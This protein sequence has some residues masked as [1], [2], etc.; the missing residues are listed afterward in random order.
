M[1]KH[2]KEYDD[3]MKSDKWHSKCK[4]RLEIADHKCEM[5]GRLENNSKGLQ[6]HHISYRNLGNEDVGNELICVCGRCHLMLHRYYNR[7]RA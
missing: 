1:Q 4:Q 3:Y 6:I 7:K 5:C 2:S